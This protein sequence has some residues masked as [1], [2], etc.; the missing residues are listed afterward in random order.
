MVSEL[1]KK[2]FNTNS[3]QKPVIKCWSYEGYYEDFSWESSYEDCSKFL[4]SEGMSLEQLND[5]IQKRKK[6]EKKL[7]EMKNVCMLEKICSQN[8][9]QLLIKRWKN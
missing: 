7:K 2:F 8:V 4:K 6:E 3:L 5:L 1:E 9:K